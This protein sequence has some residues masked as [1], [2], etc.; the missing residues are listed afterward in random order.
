MSWKSENAVVTNVGLQLLAKANA[1][2]GSMQ[3]T[4]VVT[5][6]TDSTASAN[7]ELTGTSSTIPYKQECEMLNVY[8]GRIINSDDNGGESELQVRI[9]NEDVSSSGPLYPYQIKQVIIFMRLAKPNGTYEDELPYMVAQ[10]D[11]TPD[12]MPD[13]SENPVIIN[14]DLHILH[15][16]VAQVTVLENIANY[17]TVEQLETAAGVL[18]EEIDGKVDKEQDKGL[19]TNDFDDTYKSMLDNVDTTVTEGSNR[20]ITSD[21]VFAAIA[22]LNSDDVENLKA[23]VFPHLV[24]TGT[25]N[26]DF[27]ATKG[28]VTIESSTG[29]SGSVDIIIPQLGTWTI[30]YGGNTKTV[31]IQAPMT[32]NECAL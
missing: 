19:S 15:T 6:N 30:T 10:S 32:I 22:G 27:T 12:E 17:A 2:Q 26:T 5:T 13:F 4:K 23:M 25:A 8:G 24:V 20:L 28:S 14:Y 18:E 7:R 3:I 29:S 16:G 11:G 31:N 21:A 1:G 9:T